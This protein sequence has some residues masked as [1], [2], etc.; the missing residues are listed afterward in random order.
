M[1]HGSQGTGAGRATALAACASPVRPGPEPVLVTGLYPAVVPVKI[2]G[3]TRGRSWWTQNLVLIVVA[4]LVAVGVRTFLLETFY[5]PSESMERTLLVDDHVFVN[6]VLYSLRPPRRGEVVVFEPPTR[7]AAGP[8][9]SDFIKRVIGVDGDRVVCC[10]ERYRITVNGVALDEDYLF[11]GDKPSEASFDVT[12]GSGRVFVLGDHRSDSGD[13]R[14]HLD[15]DGGT[16]P[17]NRMVGRA[18]ATFWPLTRMRLL[19][20]PATFAPVP[21]GRR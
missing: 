16:V 5:I 19:S 2:K 3:R 6:K 7:W 15:L 1:F 9:Q 17:V 8:G 10:D 12:V 20:V 14:V 13:S 21:R 4:L 18:V 11:P